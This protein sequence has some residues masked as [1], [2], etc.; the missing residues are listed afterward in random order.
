MERRDHGC[1]RVKEGS[2]EIGVVGRVGRRFEFCYFDADDLVLAQSLG[3]DGEVFEGEPVGHV[4]VG[5]HCAGFENIAVEVEVD[6]AVAD[7]IVEHGV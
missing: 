4:V 2:D 7:V 3:H 6:G 5:R 1:Q